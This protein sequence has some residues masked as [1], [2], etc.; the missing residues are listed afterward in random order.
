VCPGSPGVVVKAAL[1]VVVNSKG[2]VD[3]DERVIAL[4]RVEVA[5]LVLEGG[6]GRA[7]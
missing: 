2:V 7:N 5:G 3:R 6:G 4:G 1:V